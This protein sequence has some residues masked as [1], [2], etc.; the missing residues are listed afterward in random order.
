MMRG[1]V[2]G[3]LAWSECAARLVLGSCR[4]WFLAVSGEVAPGA[5]PTRS[6]TRISTPTKPTGQIPT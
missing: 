4:G 5:P 1:W 6:P 3:G 2:L